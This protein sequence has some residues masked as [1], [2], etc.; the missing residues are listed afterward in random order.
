MCAAHVRGE[1]LQLLGRPYVCH[2]QLEL[3]VWVLVLRLARR[4]RRVLFRKIAP[5]TAR[6][7]LWDM[8]LQ[9]PDLC[10]V[11]RAAS[12][13]FPTRVAQAFARSVLPGFF[14]MELRLRA[15]QAVCPVLLERLIRWEVKDQA[16]AFNVQ[17]ELRRPLWVLR[18]RPLVRSV[19]Q[20]V[21]LVQA[22]P[23]VPCVPQGLTR[24]R[25]VL[26]NA[27]CVLAALIA[28]APARRCL[29]RV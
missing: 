19:I 7:A 27:H 23:H 20:E 13:L 17:Q 14:L 16:L 3:L 6:F 11:R 8:L 21:L 10:S 9:A 24:P 25:L 12:D 5:A 2:V 18:L 22:R 4:V 15:P 26:W 29:T 1:H 28:R